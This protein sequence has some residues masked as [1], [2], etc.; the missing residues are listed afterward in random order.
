[1]NDGLKISAIAVDGGGT[2]CRIAGVTESGCEVV[3]KGAANAF[4][5]FDGTVKTITAGLN[6]LGELMSVPV[7]TLADTPAYLGLAGVVDQQT[8]QDLQ[9][10]LPFETV[11]I[12]GDGRSAVRAALGSEDGIVAHCGTGSFFGLQRDNTQRLVGG[13]GAVL[14][15]IA[16]ARWMGCR[17]LSLTLYATDGL[18]T[19]T[20]LT[21]H[22][23][24]L[25]GS[26]KSI[27]EFANRADA[28]EIGQ[29]AK[30]VSDFAQQNDEVAAQIFNEGAL[31]IEGIV[32]KLGWTEEP[33]CLTG[34]LGPEYV[35]YLPEVMQSKMVEPK[36]E[37]LDGAVELA[38]EFSREAGQ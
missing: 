34:G 9:K 25:H 19:M 36:G 21:K 23:M 28:S 32:S 18:V 6:E 17:A 13:W 2:H 4:T 5:D 16:S 12:E 11:K 27:L 24:D 14:D 7:D 33:V 31:L 37:P 20:G 38:L 15:D 10:A 22:V 30:T 8:G 3:V 1:M 26:P 35:P 29:L